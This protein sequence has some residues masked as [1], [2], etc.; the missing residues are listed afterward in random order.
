MSTLKKSSREIQEIIFEFLMKV[1][2]YL[3]IIASI[4]SCDKSNKTFEEIDLQGHRGARGL[5]P[6]NSLEG[7]VKVIEL[8]VNTLEMDLAVTADSQLVVSHEPYF[9]SE[10]CLDSKG[11]EISESAQLR[12]NIYQMSYADVRSFDCGSKPHPRFPEQVKFPI[13]RPLLEDVLDSI[14]SLVRLKRL[15]TMRY[16]IEVKTQVRGDEVFHPN[17]SDFSDLVYNLIDRKL[18]WNQVTIQSFDFRVLQY[19]NKTYPNV[20][21]ALLIENEMPW[22]VN[23]DSL[24]FAPEIYS[25]DYLLLSRDNI[26]KMQSEGMA[27]IPWTVNEREDMDQLL[28]WGVD[29]I[30]TDYPNRTK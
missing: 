28:K 3:I 17:P 10:I 13:I 5:W 23:I 19:F 12:N 22:K 14:E 24:G 29:G 2:V 7:F 25:C 11:N 8:G 20:R 15:D 30:I 16:N 21:L 4:I 1:L 9:S 6:E 27:V 26:G 18:P